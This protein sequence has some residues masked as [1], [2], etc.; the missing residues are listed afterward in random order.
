MSQRSYVMSPVSIVRILLPLLLACVLSAPL[1]AQPGMLK[2]EPGSAQ[3]LNLGGGVNGPLVELMPLVSPDGRTLYFDR[4]YDSNNVGGVEDADDIYYSTLL[5]NGTW[6]R[7]KNIGPPLNTPGS[8]VL[9][10]ISSDG[11][12]ALVHNGA[13][14]RERTVGL[15]ITRK[16][17]NG[18]W[19]KPKAISIAG[20][21][22]VTDNGAGYSAFISPDG[23]RLI[24]A[25]AMDSTNPE[26]L[27]L[28]SCPAI[29]SDYLR[30]GEPTTLGDTV[31]TLLYEWA[32]YMAADNTTLYFASGG[33]FGFGTCDVYVTRRLDDTW[34]NWSDPIN[35][36][37]QIN[38][39]GYEASVSVAPNGVDAYIAAEAADSSE[40]AF[41]GTD[42]FQV[43][44]IPPLRPYPMTAVNGMVRGG[45][46]PVRALV[47]AVD[48]AS[49]REVASTRAAAD[50]SF[51]LNVIAERCYRITA[52]S[53]GFNEL[54]TVLSAASLP[55]GAVD[56]QL[57][58]APE[59]TADAPRPRS[60]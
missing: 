2:A 10:W 17:K 38:T 12:T 19:G 56:L 36:G 30:W 52:W 5:P 18:K 24:L 35:L 33:H 14:V 59:A 26:N 20:L 50:G 54:P 16:G 8:D 6:S 31:N 46:R 32:P 23:R 51:R 60:Q 40:R 48:S 7:A 34:R 28:Y 53:P 41:G 57:V 9:L 27:D 44:L 21:S 1:A 39:M 55:P 47:R 13:V 49:G 3:R 22:G 11:T 29:G 15:A 37:P 43:T 4:K 58:L 42:L 45:G 25:L